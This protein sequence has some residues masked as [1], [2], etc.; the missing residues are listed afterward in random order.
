[1]TANLV[2]TGDLG[3]VADV[4]KR[5]KNLEFDR[6]ITLSALDEAARKFLLNRHLDSNSLTVGK[7][8]TTLDGLT[9]RS[10]SKLAANI[11]DLPQFVVDMLFGEAP[12]ATVA[13][14][15][16]HNVEAPSENDKNGDAQL[17]HSD[18]PAVTESIKTLLRHGDGTA[19]PTGQV[20]VR[21]L[22]I[23][24][25]WV[26]ETATVDELARLL[27]GIMTAVEGSPS[28]EPVR[29]RQLLCMAHR[30]MVA[31]SFGSRVLYSSLISGLAGAEGLNGRAALVGDTIPLV[32]ADFHD[33]VG[34]FGGNPPRDLT[35]LM[36]DEYVR[37]AALDDRKQLLMLL[38]ECFPE[39]FAHE[40]RQACDRLDKQYRIVNPQERRR[41]MRRW[42]HPHA[43]WQLISDVLDAI[44][45]AER[46]PLPI[47]MK[48]GANKLLDEV[49]LYADADL[50]A[51][52]DIESKIPDEEI[53]GPGHS[54]RNGV[55]VAGNY[56]I[57]REHVE[58]V[59]LWRAHIWKLDSA[60]LRLDREILLDL[61]P[62]SETAP[63]A[64]AEARIKRGHV[65][66]LQTWRRELQQRLRQGDYV[67]SVSDK[68]RATGKRV[69]VPPMPVLDAGEVDA[70]QIAQLVEFA[71]A[72]TA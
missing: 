5:H 68:P 31:G 55:F 52:S 58:Q 47:S 24:A 61:D 30:L 17:L 42:T 33:R 51:E 26:P 65:D 9:L 45:P 67:K 7:V 16:H 63:S 37:Q 60:L 44:W 23:A 54:D 25:G 70:S 19:S 2:P 18:G 38:S 50:P 69:N 57:N 32:L 29:E 22:N 72:M 10:R 36:V 27:T 34:E 40:V 53:H 1:M 48:D 6:K 71:A 56:M 15:V 8:R 41:K 35:C 59:G 46:G 39:T 12:G 21:R 66:A 20:Q 13:L 3:A 64:K 28:S 49:L 43:T 4:L 11:A 14:A 62:R